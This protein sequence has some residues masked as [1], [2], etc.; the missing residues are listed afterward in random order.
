[1]NEMR[2]DEAARALDEI[3]R[4]QEQVIDVAT[5]PVW[6]WWAIAALMVVL[7]AGVD[8]K[9]PV[10]I[11][12]TVTV[13]VVGLLAATG[14]FVLRALRT[15][16]RNHLLGARG[17]LTILAFEAIVIGLSLGV[18]LPLD[19]ARVGHAATIGVLVGAV[20]L[21]VGGPVL[22]RRLRQ[23]MLSNRAGSAR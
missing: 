5:I 1:M 3:R 4:R 18:A 14:T 20:L 17:V 13:F 19:A 12:V 11:G 22:M 6:Y 2:P 23:I 9:R 10:V 21:V 15:Q 16:P 7:A 8:T